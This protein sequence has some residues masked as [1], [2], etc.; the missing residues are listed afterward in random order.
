LFKLK[1][2]QVYKDESVFPALYRPFVPM[3]VYFDKVFNNTISFLPSIFPTPSHQNLAIAVSGKGSDRFY[4]FI[5]DRIVSF[6][7]LHH[8]QLFPLTL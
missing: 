5:T 3:W 1:D 2:K 7:F 4:A 6:D 8:T